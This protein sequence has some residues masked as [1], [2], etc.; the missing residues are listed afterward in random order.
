M[1]CNAAGPVVLKL[2]TPWHDGTTHLAMSAP[3]FMQRLAALAELDRVVVI[4]WFPHRRDSK[5]WPDRGSTAWIDKAH[6][7]AVAAWLVGTGTLCR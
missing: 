5:V 2:K 7:V 3:E 6:G 4:G 1:Q